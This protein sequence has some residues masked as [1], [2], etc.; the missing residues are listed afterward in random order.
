MVNNNGLSGERTWQFVPGPSV[1]DAT[2]HLLVDTAPLLEE[3]ENTGID[4]LITDA[5]YPIRFDRSRSG[6]GFS[7]GDSPVDAPEMQLS[8]IPEQGS[9]DRNLTRALV[10][11]KLAMRNLYGATSTLTLSSSGVEIAGMTNGNY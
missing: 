4:A 3:E 6:A 1:K 8:Q 9:S 5:A 10:D 11:A 7:P 2:I